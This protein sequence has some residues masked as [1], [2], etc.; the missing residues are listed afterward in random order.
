MALRESEQRAL[1]VCQL[2]F[3]GETYQRSL[4]PQPDQL[5][6]TGGEALLVAAVSAEK[7][8]DSSS[9]L[10]VESDGFGMCD[11]AGLQSRIVE[12][13]EAALVEEHAAVADEVVEA[14]ECRGATAKSQ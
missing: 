14:S 10:C 4:N 8:V 12:P 11:V 9:E 5:V 7:V 13:S 2:S 6:S 3:D 1:A